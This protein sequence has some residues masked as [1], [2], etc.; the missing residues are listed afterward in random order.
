M[1]AMCKSTCQLCHPKTGL[2]I[3]VIVVPKEGLAYASIHSVREL[4]DIAL[5]HNVACVVLL[6]I[7]VE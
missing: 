1:I 7:A 4:R 3:F 2:E 6:Y 5:D